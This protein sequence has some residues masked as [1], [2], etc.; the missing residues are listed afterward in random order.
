MQ[1]K[2]KTF[3]KSL[4]KNNN[5]FQKNRMHGK[6]KQQEIQIF[7]RGDNNNKVDLELQFAS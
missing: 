3:E 1:V 2:A 6:Q 4:K 5:F 7:G